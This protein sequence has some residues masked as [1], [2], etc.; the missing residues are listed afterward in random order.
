MLPKMAGFGAW[1]LLLWQFTAIASTLQEGSIT[2]YSFARNF[3]SVPVSL[4]G[5]A[6]ATATFPML[7]HHF[8]KNEKDLFHL[9]LKKGMKKTLLLTIPSAIGMALLST[10]IITF[11][12]GGGM[13]DSA[14]ITL[15]AL[16]LSIYTISIPSESLM[17]L[18]ARAFYARLDT[19]TPTVIQIT[20]IIIAISTAWYFSNLYGVIGIPIGFSIGSWFQVICLGVGLGLKK[21]F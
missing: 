10:F 15:T 21:S 18:F 7:S 17:H 3:Q 5:I 16:T 12:L 9:A 13:F 2:I 20:S 1:Q 6:I 14:A 19:F 8:A 4:F 11:L